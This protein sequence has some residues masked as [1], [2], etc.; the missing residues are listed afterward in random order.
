MHFQ[1]H[2][3][4]TIQRSDSGNASAVLSAAVRRSRRTF[5]LSEDVAAFAERRAACSLSK[6]GARMAGGSRRRRRAVRQDER[7]MMK[8]VLVQH[9]PAADVTRSVSE[10][11]RSKRPRFESVPERSPSLTL[12]VTSLLLALAWLF[13]IHA[14]AVAQD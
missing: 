5:A 13:G 1:G 6:L 11:E 2:E 3:P 14:T 4:T 7:M 8:S 9:R 12:R 10:G